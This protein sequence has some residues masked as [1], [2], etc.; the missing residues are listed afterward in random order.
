GTAAIRGLSRGSLS[1]ARLDAQL[2]L[3]GGRGQVK[4]SAAGARGRDFA[5]QAIA[6]LAPDRISVS[7][8]G[9]IDR[10][11]IALSQ[12][13]VLTLEG[14]AWRLSS[15]TLSFAGGSAAVSGLFGKDVTEF[16]A[17]MDAMPLTALDV[18]N[19]G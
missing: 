19:P 4:L 18:V 13:A 7:G 16:T 12:P 15:T 14:N 11:P 5:L 6:D 1:L 2:R 3:R 17:R 9:T 8:S 10:L